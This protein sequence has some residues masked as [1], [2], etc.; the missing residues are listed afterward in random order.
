MPAFTLDFEN[1]EPVMY[2]YAELPDFYAGSI[3]RSVRKD[4][5]NYVSEEESSFIVNRKTLRGSYFKLV[6]DF[7]GGTEIQYP[8][9]CFTDGYYV[10]NVE[11]AILLAE[12]EEVLE[13]NKDLPVSKINDL[14]DFKN[15]I[16]ENDNNYILLGKLKQEGWDGLQKNAGS[17]GLF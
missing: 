8:S 4:Q 17:G 7:F 9:F 16:T 1:R 12:L 14:T 5:L 13:K 10:R 6:N 2:S 15:S 3:M 11:P